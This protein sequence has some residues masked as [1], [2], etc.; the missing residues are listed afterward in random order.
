[1]DGWIKLHRKITEWEWYNDANT[2][3]VFIHCLLLANHE[4][5]KWRGQVIKRGSFITS[6]SKLAARLKLTPK[7]TRTAIEK[8]KS[9]ENLASEWHS[10]YSIITIKNYNSYQTTGQAEGRQRA[11]SCYNKNDKND[12]KESSSITT[13]NVVYIGTTHF[14][15]YGSYSNVYLSKRQYGTLLTQTGSEKLLGILIDELSENIASKS[16]KDKVFD[17]NHPNMHYIR[18][19]KYLRSYL[20]RKRKEQPQDEPRPYNPYL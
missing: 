10:Q 7:Q 5:I 4:D 9:S 19:T 12:K 13:N 16:D 20:E 6:Y 15:V 17:E 3:R 18:L 11:G 1:M 2:F 14:D 8:L